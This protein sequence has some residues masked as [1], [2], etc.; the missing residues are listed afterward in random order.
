MQKICKTTAIIYSFPFI[1][2]TQRQVYFGFIL[3]L[4]FCFI[5]LMLTKFKHQLAGIGIILCV[6]PITP[7][8][9]SPLYQR[10]CRLGITKQILLHVAVY[11]L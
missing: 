7:P 5:R 9:I 6:E 4:F 2:Q 8:T 3:N 11:L 10:L 1:K